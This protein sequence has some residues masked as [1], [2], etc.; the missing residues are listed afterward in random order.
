MSEIENEL[1]TLPLRALL[2]AAFI[3][4]LSAAPEDRRRHCL[5]VWTAQ[6]GLQSKNYCIIFKLSTIVTDIYD[7]ISNMKQPWN[8]L[9]CELSEFVAFFNFFKQM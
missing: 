4:Y 2:A 8:F 9:I 3:T 7:V 6:S 1:N 5:E